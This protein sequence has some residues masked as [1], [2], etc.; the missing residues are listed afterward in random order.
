[1]KNNPFRKTVI[2]SLVGLG[3]T[4][5]F[6]AAARSAQAKN[7]THGDAAKQGARSE[8]NLAAKEK[9]TVH[10][11]QPL[12]GEG[13]SEHE[14]NLG[15]LVA[16]A[17]RQA[18]HADI[19]FLPADEISETTIPVGD[20]KP[21]ELAKALRYTNDPSDTIVVLDLT[22]AQILQAAE[23]S[24]SHLPQPFPG[25][26]QVSGLQVRYD[27]AQPVG[28][29]VKLAGADS[30][31]ISSAKTYKVATTRT[32]AG[33]GLGYFK[34][35]KK[36]DADDETKISVTKALTDYLTGRAT[37]TA[38]VEGRVAPLK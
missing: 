3:L 19:A 23:R 34:V 13:A 21:A 5:A 38:T 31:E 2:L 22:G 10:I 35:W 37:L 29:R 15:N 6:A 17:I 9:D 11:A 28:K 16:D 7:E 25:F 26:L 33:G 24:V 20:V 18:S 1:M 27:P 32:L 8:S 36:S 30:S 12:V 4:A 14:T